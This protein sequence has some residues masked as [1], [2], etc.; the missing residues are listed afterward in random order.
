MDCMSVISF[1]SAFKEAW[2][3]TAIIDGAARCLY[4]NFMKRMATSLQ[5]ELLPLKLQSSKQKIKEGVCA[6]YNHSLNKLPGT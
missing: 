4:Q 3:N 6:T 1:P 2:D 5:T